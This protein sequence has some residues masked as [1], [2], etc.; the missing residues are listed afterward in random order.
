MPE[1][2]SRCDFVTDH[3]SRSH[4]ETGMAHRL[5]A[6]V[7]LVTALASATPAYAI[8]I[9][10]T[11]PAE[12]STAFALDAYAE[13]SKQK[14]NLAFSPASIFLALSLLQEGAGGDDADRLATAMRLSGWRNHDDGLDAAI[15]GWLTGLTPKKQGK[16]R[17]EI[18]SGIWAARGT[19]LLPSYVRRTGRSLGA[20][21][22]IADFARRPD[23]SRK[24]IN[25]WI[26]AHTAKKIRDL[27]PAGSIARDTD[28]VLA[29]A[30]YF[31]GAWATEFEAAATRDGD[32]RLDDGKTATV[33]MMHRSGAARYGAT[34]DAQ[35]LELPYAGSSLAMDLILPADG[36]ALADLEPTIATRFPTWIAALTDQDE[37]T[38]AFPRFTI[39][40]RTDLKA[41]MTALGLG[42][43]FTSLDV[44][45]MIRNPREHELSGAFHQTF[46][47]VNE[48]GTEAAAATGLVMRPTS[49]RITPSFVADRPFL[50]AIRDTTTG[51]IVFV[52][53]VADPR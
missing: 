15:A 32:F 37:V 33:R 12:A 29:N 11:Q 40:Q 13:L 50:W 52:G 45:R 3:F 10:Q 43:L 2:V 24:A 20:R 42:S 6:S 5:T 26:S 23:H 7:L 48:R 14:G 27:L 34:K 53:R 8:R 28:V 30:V 39:D 19:R 4:V 22:A 21:A 46:V 47:E 35:V 18:A 51:T 49:A 41:L 31:K 38:I 17:L 44:S 25:A 36:K 1:E 16:T 9:K